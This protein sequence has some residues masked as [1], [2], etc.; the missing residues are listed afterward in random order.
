V[1]ELAADRLE[2]L[3]AENKR[4]RSALADL[5]SWFPEMPS[6][7]EWRLKSGEYGADDAIN[8]AR[9]ALKGDQS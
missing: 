8:A 1:V 5:I 2:A 4:L 9:S 6:P 7:P 3:E